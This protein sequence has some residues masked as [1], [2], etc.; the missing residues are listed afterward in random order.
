MHALLGNV[1]PSVQ[2]PFL[3]ILLTVGLTMGIHMLLGS[4]MT[5]LSVAV[6]LLMSLLPAT[7]NPTQIMLVIFIAI[8]IHYILPLHHAVV[9]IG[10]GEKYYTTGM[11]VKYGLFLTILVFI[12]VFAIALPYW[13]LIS[14]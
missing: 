12:A 11:T 14:L 6:P 7:A 8:N 1:I 10:E 2:N 5:S 4:S 13:K 9:M 3:F